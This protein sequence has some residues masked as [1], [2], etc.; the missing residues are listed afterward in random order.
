MLILSSEF[1]SKNHSSTYGNSECN[2]FKS[3]KVLVEIFDNLP[4]DLL[5]T[6]IYKTLQFC[7]K[8]LLATL[9]WTNDF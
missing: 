9:Q 8:S 6:N 4:N 7:W 1:W 3:I 2:V 5:G